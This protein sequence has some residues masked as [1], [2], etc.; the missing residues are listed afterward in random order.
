MFIYLFMY[1]YKCKAIRSQA[2]V[3]T[4]IDLVTA[5][6][7]QS[8]GTAMELPWQCPGSAMPLPWQY[9]GTAMARP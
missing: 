6:A 3:E 1:T 8:H 2:S 4:D 7:L 9:H 5:M